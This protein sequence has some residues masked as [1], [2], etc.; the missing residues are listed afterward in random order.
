MIIT[1]AVIVQITTVSIKGSNKE[2]SPS[3]AEY[4]VLTAE[5]AIEAEPA[6]ASFEKAALLNPTNKT[7]ITLPTP[8]AGGLKASE[9]IKLKASSIN[10]K[11]LSII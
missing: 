3:E 6:P 2:T 5:C 11:L 1:R 7:P 4:F 10:E 8:I 9:I